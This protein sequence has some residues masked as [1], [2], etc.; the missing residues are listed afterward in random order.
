M[1]S[2]RP[3]PLTTCE[4]RPAT[5]ADAPG[6][7][8]LWQRAREHN[9]R[10]DPRVVLAPV[11]PDQFAT[12]LERQL[13]RGAATVFVAA[14]RTRLAGFVSGAIETASADRLPER[15]ATIGYLWVE[16]GYR[17]RGLGRALVDAVARWAAGYDGVRHFEMPVLAA[18][19][20]A[21]R[22]WEALGFRPFI[23]RLWAPLAREPD[24]GGAP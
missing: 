9:A 5:P 3:V 1:A 8:L 18:D 2:L 4:I 22:F 21:A 14:D 13:N 19:A 16:P 11:A 12:A 10:L 17:R 23:T 6:L 24:D 15:H 20:E 7:Y